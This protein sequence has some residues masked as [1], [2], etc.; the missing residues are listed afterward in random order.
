MIDWIQHHNFRIEQ[1]IFLGTMGTVLILF[2]MAVFAQQIRRGVRPTWPLPGGLVGGTF[3]IAIGLLP[4]MMVMLRLDL[5]GWDVYGWRQTLVYF[6]IALCSTATMVRW[7]R[8]GLEDDP[9]W[10]GECERRK[11]YDRRHGWGRKEA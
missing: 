10:D 4:L 6:L 1:V 5:L 11:D 3:L 8:K 9:P 7:Y 2:G